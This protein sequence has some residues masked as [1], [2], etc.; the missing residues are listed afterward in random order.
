[1]SLPLGAVRDANIDWRL[2]KVQIPAAAYIQGPGGANGVFGASV[3][4]AGVPIYASI[5]SNI[6]L[7]AMRL[8]A[9]T[10]NLTHLWWAYDIDVHHPVYVRHLWTT[11]A[12]TAGQQAVFRTLYSTVTSGMPFATP[13]QAL[14]VAIASSSKANPAGAA[15]QWSPWGAVAPIATGIH[16]NELWPESVTSV[17]WRHNVNAVNAINLT[18]EFVYL[19]ATEYAY[20]PRMTYG[21]GSRREARAGNDEL[22]N[23]GAGAAVDFKR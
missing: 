5:T 22:T 14:T 20:T 9:T 2:K 12:L 6:G 16:A 13:S 18:N 3:L 23:M 7:G 19:V 10:D 4:N 17:V 1:M 21:D 15:A 11:N 8:E